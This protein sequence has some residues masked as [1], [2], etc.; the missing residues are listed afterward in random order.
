MISSN[1]LKAQYFWISINL[2]SIKFVKFLAI[3]WVVGCFDSKLLKINIRHLLKSELS[4]HQMYSKKLRQFSKGSLVSI[5][6][7]SSK[8]N[9]LLKFLDRHI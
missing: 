5:S 9:L 1:T 6:S 3:I 2:A 4:S 8:I 7:E